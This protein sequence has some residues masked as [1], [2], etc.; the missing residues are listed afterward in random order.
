VAGVGF[1]ET[2]PLRV[3]PLKGKRFSATLSL[4]GGRVSHA[5]RPQGTVTQP[6][7][8]LQVF[9]FVLLNRLAGGQIRVF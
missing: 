1:R 8:V 7:N 3:K 2:V 6:N 5:L 9:S 4:H